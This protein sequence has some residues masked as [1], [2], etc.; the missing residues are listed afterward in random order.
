MSIKTNT[1]NLQ[2]LLEQVNTLPEANI[3]VDADKIIPTTI[4]GYKT[5]SIND[6]SEIPHNITI[7]CASDVSVYGKNFLH[8]KTSGTQVGGD[9]TAV[10]NAD[11]SITLK[12]GVSTNT[13]VF[14]FT[15]SV[16]GYGSFTLPTGTY[17]LSLGN[18]DNKKVILVLGVTR[19][20]TI[21][22]Y[23]ND[24]ESLRVVNIQDGDSLNLY[25]QIKA[26][27]TLEE[28]LTVYPQL[29]LG[30]IPTA[31]E[32]YREPIVVTNGTIKSISP[33]MSFI[34]DSGVDIKVSYRKSWGMYEEWNRFWDVYQ[35][36]IA[37]RGGYPYCFYGGGWTPATFKPKYDFD[38]GTNSYGM[39]G[40]SSIEE[41]NKTIDARNCTNFTQAFWYA[42]KLKTITLLKVSE[43]TTFTNAFGYC[44]ALENITFE[45]EICGNI[46]LHWSEKLTHDSLM[47][48]INALKDYSG[49]GTTY[50]LT[51][52]ADAKARL[53]DD[54][55]AIATQKGWTVA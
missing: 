47:S 6:I 36:N 44:S 25:L 15:P 3:S 35:G 54:E 1:T 9:I 32:Q 53:S 20:G 49:S 29:E 11:G 18:G 19:N 30:T 26:K 17:C 38:C 7:E 37:S 41:I 8:T 12:A 46:D 22:Y 2:A 13:A 27:I 28:D 24:A 50:T 45:G 39:F 4:T 51:L 23:Q 31:Y 40:W 14:N 16:Y 52:H 43:K 34:A 33:N 10:Y 42:Q 48:I 5:V 21:K 55:I